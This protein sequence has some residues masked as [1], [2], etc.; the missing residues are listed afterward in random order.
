MKTIMSM[1]KNCQNPI[2]WIEYVVYKCSML[3]TNH[4]DLLTYFGLG[5][6]Y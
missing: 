5:F 6:E 2:E 3:A 4:F 1:D